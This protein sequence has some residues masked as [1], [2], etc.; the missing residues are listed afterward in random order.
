MVKKL[1]L[2]FLLFF[3]ITLSSSGQD[4]EGSWSWNSQ[5]GSNMFSIDLMRISENN[6]RGNHCSVYLGGDRIDCRENGED[7]TIVLVRKSE[8]IFQGSIRSGLSNSIGNVQLQYLP[9][10]D[11]I[12]FSLKTNPKG[13]YY[14]PLEGRLQRN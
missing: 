12:I 9:N 4:I 5:D 10:E 3:F 14:M 8:N 11:N 7:F 13:E 2:A 6:Y 1:Q